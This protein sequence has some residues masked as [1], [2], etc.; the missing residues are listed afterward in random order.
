MSDVLDRFSPATREWFSGAF[1][2]PTPAQ[3]GAWD[4][5]SRGS[6]TLVVAPTGSG[7]TLAAFLWA[8]DSL[9]S[10]ADGGASGTSATAASPSADAAGGAPAERSTRVLYISP[11]KALGVDVERN[12]R[13]PLVG[14]TQTARRLGFEPPHVSVGVRSGDTVPADRRLL[15]KNPP[16]ILI[17]T[18]ESLFLMLT[19]AARET[20]A[21]VDTVIIDEVHAVAATKR[22]AHLALSLERLDAMLARPA[23][24]IGLSATVRPHEEVARFLSGRAPVQ[25]VAPASTKKF[26]LRVVVPVDDMSELG[27]T[28]A[29]GGDADANEPG[30]ARSGSIWPHVEER[31]VDLILEHR[32][33]IVFANSRRLA[34]RLTARFNEIYA[35]RMADPPE[36]D[37]ARVPDELAPDRFTPADAQPTSS[38]ATLMGQAGATAG[39]DPQ[40]ARAHHG[41][42]SKEQRALI[43]DDLKSGRLRCV[44]AT[45]SLELGI[46]MG[47]VDLVVQVESPPSVASGLQRVGR[48]GHQVGEV[49]RGVLFPKHR[50]DLIHSTVTA[51]RMEAGL[52]ESLAVPANPLDV[53]AQQTVA[54]VALEPI[55]ADDWFD[56]VRRSASFGGLGRGVFEATLDLLAGR[57][58][59]DRFAE[60]RPRIVWDRDSG[61]LTGR[62]GAQR[63]AVTSGGTIPDRG[64]FGVFLASGATG[65]ATTG[66]TRVGELDEEMVYE[67]RV[68]DVFALGSTSWRIHEITH[69]RVLVTPA[70]GEPGRLPFWKGDGLGRPLE[71]GRAV[72]AFLR[73]IA[74]GDEEDSRA[75]CQAVGLDAR[76]VNNLL[77]FIAEQRVA[78][79]HVPT[80][81]T[82]VLE[83]CYD[84]LGDWRLILHSSFGMKVHAPWA[85]AVGARVRERYGI[86]GSCMAS[87]DGLIVRIPDTE[88]DPPGA[89]LFVFEP[90]ELAQIVTT[91]VGGSALFASRFR[92]CAARALLLPKYNPGKRSPLWQQ[93]Q[94]ASQLLDVARDYPQFPIILETV[95]EC[96]QDVYDLPG[97]TEIATQI[98]SRAIRIVET[99]T[100]QASPFARS[101][102]FGYVASFIYEGDSP[103]AERRAAALSLD[104]GLLAELLGQA[105]L[106]ELLDPVVLEQTERELQ[107]LAPERQARGLEGVADL[108]RMLGPLTTAEVAARTQ[109]LPTAE[110]ARVDPS[111]AEGSG[112]PSPGSPHDETAMSHTTQAEAWLADLVRSKRALQVTFAQETWWTAIE[113]AARL[114]DALGVPIPF[115]VPDAFIE[116]VADPLGDLLGRY[117]RTHTPFTSTEAATRFGLGAAVAHDTLRRLAGAGQIVEGEFRPHGAGAE[118]CDNQVLRRLRNRSLAALRHEVEPVD[119]HALGRFLPAWQGVGGAMHGV[120]GVASVIEQLA[121]VPLP[122]SAWESL[123]LPS[124]VADYSAAMLD[125]LTAAGEVIWAGA[126]NLPGKD[127]WVSLHL[128]ETAPLTLATPQSPELGELHRA[129]LDTL[130]GG[131]G[132]FFRQLS[133]AVGSTDDDA[134]VT[135]CWDL[136]WAGLVTNDTFAPLRVL[137]GA[138]QSAHRTPRRPPRTRMHSLRAYARSGR[139]GQISRTGP[140]TAQGRWSLLPEVETDPT[141]RAK[142]NA[143]ALLERYGVVTRG[144]VVAE[145]VAGGFALVYRVL[146]GFEDTGR[147]RR[148]YFVEGLGA[149]Q[150]ATGGT[151]DR[152]RSF[153]RA[154]DESPWVT[155]DPGAASPSRDARHSTA[156]DST[157]RSSTTRDSTT[158]GGPAVVALAATDPANPYGAA[159][160]WPAGTGHRPGRKAGALVVLVDGALVLYVERGGKSVLAF[161]DG[162]PDAGPAASGPE[163]TS[164]SVAGSV[165]GANPSRAVGAT[166]GH[167]SSPPPDPV[168]GQAGPAIRLATDALAALVL[169]GGVDK[170]TIEKI[171]G[172]FVIGTPV[173]AALQ[174]SGFT[175]IPRG[176]RLRR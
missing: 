151:I 6:H 98:E 132:Y 52:I 133:D 154:P 162:S 164:G 96:L 153:Q 32:S 1:P 128:A 80:D 108:L 13:S 172:E 117:A 5:I 174:A 122:A 25:I 167:A 95:R 72:G 53:L 81:R 76:A 155:S 28:V 38:P 48:A 11:L 21:Q 145:Q 19:S 87:D 33:S 176:L 24:R 63:L 20:L 68:G 10:R 61:T 107:R 18:P 119:R 70:F 165:A 127:G 16:D 137:T 143:E 125:E 40:L 120:D 29:T 124:R 161:E 91:E 112:Q 138:G 90:A 66:G 88:S 46:D 22:G 44:V 82:L 144:S 34:E 168:G 55:N 169:R 41:S 157:T 129:V 77:A 65:S 170:L 9:A 71:L 42:V 69:D 149:A 4:A 17:T 35:E 67:S 26:D 115:G 113:D 75:R 47:E 156:R 105:E 158:R 159:L 141:V 152:L 173:G 86:D 73:E 123:V 116:P 14:I 15:V 166:S 51:E 118:W 110:A 160:P 103:L 135:A 45:S 148:G 139:S 60:L 36:G 64:L 99:Q 93:R 150:F 57:Y 146:S 121:G 102:L 31:I 54:A 142:A 94:K 126:G 23:Q 97:L 2:A 136:A 30:Q 89:E 3:I 7:K 171:N 140:P 27:S 49:S 109:P 111:P 83:R 74:T 43:E 62:P 8:I 147:C 114:R 78:T 79:G 59:S 101:L 85:L 92:E 104:A 56:I 84:E 100:E 39:A 130:S 58:P 12:L 131:G 163:P 134:L 37:P 106:R 50:A 175:A